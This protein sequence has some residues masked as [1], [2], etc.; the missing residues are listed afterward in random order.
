MFPQYDSAHIFDNIER[1]MKLFGKSEPKE[2]L[3]LCLGGYALHRA[4]DGAFWGTSDGLAYS[5]F[6]EKEYA[7]VAQT[8]M[9]EVYPEQQWDIIFVGGIWLNKDP[10][11][12]KN[13][14]L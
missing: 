8:H 14:E 7:E 3:R 13:K 2:K 9:K 4:S 10:R 5:L 6:T 1:Y 12:N 11:E